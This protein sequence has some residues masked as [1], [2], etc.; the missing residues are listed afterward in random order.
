MARG[1]DMDNTILGL[2]QRQ[3]EKKVGSSNE[4]C[5][6]N[7]ITMIATKEDWKHVINGRV[8]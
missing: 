3:R 4:S 5:G 8:A 6:K 7:A 1:E 2:A